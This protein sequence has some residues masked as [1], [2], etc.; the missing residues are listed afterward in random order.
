MIEFELIHP[1]ATYEMLGLIPAFLSESNSLSAVEQLHKFY[2]HGGGW[3][4]FKG[5][6]MLPSGDMQY[7]G[8]PP[9]RLLAEAKLRDEIVRVYEH[10]WVAVLQPNGSFEVCRMD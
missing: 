5:F 9:T 8:D 6:D 3:N 10:A 7:P 1:Q 2:S 4:P